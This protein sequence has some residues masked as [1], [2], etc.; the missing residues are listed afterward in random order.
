[1][2]GARVA[3]TGSAGE[4]ENIHID[5]PGF[6]MRCSLALVMAHDNEHRGPRRAPS[7][8]PVPIDAGDQELVESWRNG[9]AQAGSTLIDRHY[10]RIA[11]FF[12]NK[13]SDAAQDDLVQ[14]TF[15]ACVEGRERFRSHSSFRTYLFAIAH[16][17]LNE[18]LRRV[19]L[20]LK[21]FDP[22]FDLELVSVADMGQSPE[23]MAVSHE[24]Q[25]LLLEGLRRIPMS[26]QVVLELHYWEQLSVSEIAEA[27]GIPLGTAKTRLRDGRQALQKAVAS[28]AQSQALLQSTIDNLDNW[29]ARIYHYHQARKGEP[30]K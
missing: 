3:S 12:K 24:E 6:A 8:P 15:L 11:R 14:Q 5:D 10:P 26:F 9:D 30:R 25:R 29:A 2:T 22:A 18:Y 16:N 27:L 21:R 1:M 4:S 13:V 23:T 7:V 17:V 20:T 28:L 19:G